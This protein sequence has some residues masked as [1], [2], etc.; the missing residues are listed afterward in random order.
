MTRDAVKALLFDFDG[1]LADTA[2]DLCVAVN[3]LRAE[4]GLDALPVDQARPYASSGARGLLRAAFGMTPE[5]PD[6]EVMRDAFL[7]HY[8]ECLDQ[9]TTLFPGIA[10]LIEQLVARDIAWG[11]VTNKATRFTERIVAGLGLAPDCVV[12]GDTTPHSK[13]HPAPL[14]HAAQVLA[15]AP[16]SCWYIGDDL[17]D[18]QAARA[19]GMRA[20]AV[21]YGYHGIE[22]G[23]PHSWN[24]DAVITHPLELL[25]QIER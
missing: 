22:N 8:A 23:G 11:I 12:C 2:A 5:H 4:R 15:L 20:I 16:A 13:P 18:V 1:T 6:Y 17:R 9:H 21:E 19:A 10:P 25:A 14:L 3:R 24:A 7:R